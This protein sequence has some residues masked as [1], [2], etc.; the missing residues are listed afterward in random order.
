MYRN[1][2][3]DSLWAQPCQKYALPQKKVQIKVFQN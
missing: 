2:N 1:G 3:L